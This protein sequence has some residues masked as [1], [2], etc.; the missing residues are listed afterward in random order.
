MNTQAAYDAWSQFR[1]AA[2]VGGKDE[3]DRLVEMADFIVDNGIANDGG[4]LEL[5]FSQSAVS[6]VLS[7]RRE[8]TLPQIKRL[9]ARFSVP[10]DCLNS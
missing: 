1:A 10:T 2:G 6:H 8:L 9:A 5:P 4:P 3:Y 7:G